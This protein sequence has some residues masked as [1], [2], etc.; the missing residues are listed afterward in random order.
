MLY[1]VDNETEIGGKLW[2]LGSRVYRNLHLSGLLGML[3]CRACR[4]DK[5]EEFIR[6]EIWEGGR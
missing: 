4:T 3:S 6:E 2:A 1:I 5:I